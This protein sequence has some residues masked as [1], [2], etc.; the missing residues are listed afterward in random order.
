MITGL[1]AFP[2]LSLISCGKAC[3]SI[4]LSL[5]QALQRIRTFAAPSIYC[6]SADTGDLLATCGGAV[7]RSRMACSAGPPGLRAATQSQQ[8]SQR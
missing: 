3:A 2:G 5:T 6:G 8:P 1:P 7:N 4:A